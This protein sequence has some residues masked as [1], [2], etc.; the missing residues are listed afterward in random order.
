V[1]EADIRGLLKHNE[2]AAD[3]LNHARRPA[4]RDVLAL[5]EL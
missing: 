3:T 4:P 5:A 2:I 1:E